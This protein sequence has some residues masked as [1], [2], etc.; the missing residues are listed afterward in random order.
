M[1][2]CFIVCLLVVINTTGSFSDWLVRKIRSELYYCEVCVCDAA[3]QSKCDVSN[4]CPVLFSHCKC[5]IK[6][7]CSTVA[8]PLYVLSFIWWEICYSVLVWNHVSAAMWIGF[9]WCQCL[10]QAQAGA[11]HQGLALMEL[12]A[13]QPPELARLCS[14]VLAQF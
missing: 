2:K 3:N 5:F 13:Q 9:W 12:A 7:A 1:N 8:H 10:C 11:A 14:M 4:T 6:S